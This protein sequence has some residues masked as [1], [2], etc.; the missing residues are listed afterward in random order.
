M[1][2]HFFGIR[3]AVRE[4]P[5]PFHNSRTVP[6]CPHKTQFRAKALPLGPKLP[7]NHRLDPLGNNKPGP[8]GGVR[9]EPPVATPDYQMH[10][11]HNLPSQRS[12]NKTSPKTSTGG[13]SNVILELTAIFNLDFSFHDD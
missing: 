11:I 3:K 4:P 2:A 6:A 12:K 7:P 10:Q 1:R 8:R 5:C 9:P 13:R